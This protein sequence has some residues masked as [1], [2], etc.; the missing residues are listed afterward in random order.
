MTALAL[1][2]MHARKRRR[3]IIEVYD[4][5]TGNILP[6]RPHKRPQIVATGT[7]RTVSTA[8]QDDLLNQLINR[9]DKTLPDDATVGELIDEAVST[10]ADDAPEDGIWIREGLDEQPR[11]EVSAYMNDGGKRHEATFSWHPMETPGTPR[12]TDH[13]RHPRPGRPHDTSQAI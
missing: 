1:A 9:L 7:Q 13:A 4:P 8:D 2:V 12:A 5:Q 6:H 10:F 11:R 3:P